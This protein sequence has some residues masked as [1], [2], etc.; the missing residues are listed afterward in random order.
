MMAH[1][2]KDTDAEQ[3]ILEAFKVFDRDGDGFIS[4][5]E[6]RQ[7]MRNL[8]ERSSDGEIDEMIREATRSGGG[9]SS[10]RINYAHFVKVMMARGAG[11]GGGGGGGGGGGCDLLDCGL[12]GNLRADMADCQLTLESEPTYRSIGHKMATHCRSHSLQRCM[13]AEPAM[14]QQ[15]CYAGSAKKAFG[16]QFQT[17]MASN[18]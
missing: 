15:Q 12:L 6:L 7:V 4:A 1:K 2:M 5:D 8:G 18:Q 10:G 3:E 11:S 13:T 17:K 9:G 16:R 14:Q